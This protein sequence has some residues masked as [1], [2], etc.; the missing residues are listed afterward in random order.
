MDI[1]S[2]FKDISNTERKR[3]IPFD[4]NNNIELFFIVTVEIFQCKQ[5]ISLPC[6]KMFIKYKEIKA[7]K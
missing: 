5:I 3:E 6:I 2:S 1:F 7:E 4:N